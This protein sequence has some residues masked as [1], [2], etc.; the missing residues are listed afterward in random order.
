M[1][2]HFNKFSVHVATILAFSLQPHQAHPSRQAGKNHKTG[3]KKSKSVLWCD[4]I[5]ELEKETWNAACPFGWQLSHF[6][7]RTTF[8]LLLVNDFVSK[9][10]TCLYM[11]LCSLGKYICVS[12]KNPLIPDYWTGLVLSPEE[13]IITVKLVKWKT[14]LPYVKMKDDKPWLECIWQFTIYGTKHKQLYTK[15]N[16]YKYMLLLYIRLT[17]KNLMVESIQSIHN[18]LWTWHDKCNIC[19]RYC[20]YHVKFN[21][22]L[23]TKPLGVFSSETEWLNVLLLFLRMN[24]FQFMF[25]KIF[26]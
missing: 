18:S 14:N 16:G 17:M 24:Y 4:S 21:V 2:H 8:L 19:C 25:I 13:L 23:V 7:A 3:K 1:P 15:I 9:R 6:L 11:Y 10:M 20:I 26:R 12:S 5:A 22:C